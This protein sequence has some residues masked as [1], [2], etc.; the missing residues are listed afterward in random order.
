MV[1]HFSMFMP[2]IYLLLFQD[3]K[4]DW[5]GY[6]INSNF[7]H[8]VKVGD[9]GITVMRVNAYL[10]GFDNENVIMISEES[11]RVIKKAKDVC[12]AVKNQ[13][14][15][16]VSNNYMSINIRSKSFH[17]LNYRDGCNAYVYY[18]GAENKQYKYSEFIDDFFSNNCGESPNLTPKKRNQATFNE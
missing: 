6:S 16:L 8:I 14:V 15:R 9:E 7:S 10:N 5:R 1:A 17:S 18:E 13:C 3:S 11:E 2:T 12:E 4:I